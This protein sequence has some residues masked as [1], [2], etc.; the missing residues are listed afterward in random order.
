MATGLTHMRVALGHSVK[1]PTYA[2]ISLDVIIGHQVE[3]APAGT[4]RLWLQDETGDMIQSSVLVGSDV[5]LQLDSAYIFGADVDGTDPH[6]ETLPWAPPLVNGIG[7]VAGR[8]ADRSRTQ[9]CGLTY[10]GD[11]L[12]WMRYDLD[13]ELGADTTVTPVLYAMVSFDAVLTEIS[14]GGVPRGRIL[15]INQL[16]PAHSML[17]V[18]LDIVRSGAGDTRAGLAAARQQKDK[19]KLE[20]MLAQA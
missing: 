3:G 18:E 1:W 15:R 4:K 7:V 5:D 17:L 11:D 13:L 10:C 2:T 14:Q 12:R 16:Q 19:R 9:I 6:S 20:E 8:S